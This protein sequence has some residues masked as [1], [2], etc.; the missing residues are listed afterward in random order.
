MPN[1]KTNENK[2]SGTIAST[3]TALSILLT[4]QNGTNS[5][6]YVVKN[7]FAIVVII[8]TCSSVLLSVV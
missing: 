1:T 3:M 4:Q 6:G 8:P 7:V 5:V 2:K